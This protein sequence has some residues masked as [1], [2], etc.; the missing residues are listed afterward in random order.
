MKHTKST[1][2]LT[3]MLVLAAGGAWMFLS[4]ERAEASE[5]SAAA[6]AP[7]M[8]VTVEVMQPQKVKLWKQFSGHVVAVDRAEIRPQVSGRIKEVLFDD[9]QYVAQGDTLIVIDPRPYQA[10]LDQA[11]AEYT[12]AQTQAHLAEKEYQRAKSLIE[13]EAIAQSLFDQRLNNRSLSA[14]SV[15]AAQAKLT[16]AQLDL[17]YAY[18]K[19]PIG[20]KVSRAEITA[21]NLVQAGVNAPLLT[22]IVSEG[23]VYVDFEIDE[24]TY[25]NFAG[26]GQNA[27]PE[28]IV[29][30]LNIGENIG[31]YTGKLHS[32]DN[33]I[34]AASGTIRARA[35]FQNENKVLLPGMSISVEMAEPTSAESIILSERAIGTD[36][37]RKY[38]YTVN[39]DNIVKYREVKIGESLGG[40]RVILSGLSAGDSVITKG[41]AHI[42]PE[43]PVSPHEAAE[44]ASVD[45]TNK[46]DTDVGE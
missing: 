30:R 1:L 40:Q 11:E 12:S 42:R 15:K 36:Q 26:Y 13:K 32:F 41:L 21:G 38:V 14:A 6:P 25:M 33:K 9:G 35:I 39:S 18:V 27:N 23:S 5:Q 45:I 24:T 37:D 3:T 22:S 28:R 44:L 19:A 10:A 17:D 20:G 31:A 43:M 4:D 7:A 16:R 8:P 46:T 34:D 29:V 2:L